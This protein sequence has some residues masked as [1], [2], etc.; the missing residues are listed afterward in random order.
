MRPFYLTICVFLLF[1]TNSGITQSLKP[2]IGQSS[3]PSESDLICPIQNYLGS[4][5]NSGYQLGDTV[6]DFTLYDTAFRFFTL[7]ESLKKG[8]PVLLI[9]SSY[10]CPIFRGKIPIIN[11]LYEKYKN[12]VD[13]YVVYTV[14]AHPNLDISPYFGKVNTGATNIK[15]NILYRQPIHYGDRLAIIKDMLQNVQLDVP[16]IID[17][18]CNEWWYHYGPAPNNATLIDTNGVVRIKHAWFDRD[19]DDIFCDL[20]S[21]LQPGTVCDSIPTGTGKFTFSMISDSVIYGQSGSSLY[22]VGRIENN[23]NATVKIEVRRLLNNMPAQWSSSI[24]LDVCYPTEVDSTQISLKPNQ[25]MDLIVD[26]FTGPIADEGSV[27][28]GLKNIDDSQN[29]NIMRVK[30]ITQ[31]VTD[32]KSISENQENFISI[33]PQPA[34]SSLS[35]YSDAF[36]YYQLYSPNGKLIYSGAFDE[37]ILL[38]IQNLTAGIYILKLSDEQGKC[39]LRKVII[40]T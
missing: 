39:T 6:H 5:E 15:E 32:A 23:S 18:P 36:S 21:Y 28:I 3:I 10:T 13:M 16:V 37:H 9:S 30:A 17:G 8:K 31:D 11:Q 19:P 4:F 24:C 40:Q 2:F 14:E 29:R 26:F 7:S 27:R 12:Q 25:S 38:D 20:I 1:Q 33:Y 35:I 34:R 22:A